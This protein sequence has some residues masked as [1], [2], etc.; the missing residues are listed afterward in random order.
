VLLL[1]RPKAAILYALFAIMVP[2]WLGAAV[3]LHHLPTLSLIAILPSI[4]L[5]PKP[6]AWAFK[7]PKQ[8]VPIP[9]LGANVVWNLSTNTVLALTL[10]V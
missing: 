4:I 10:F 5:L 9:A 6:L 1:G 7:Q 2:V 8:P 3:V